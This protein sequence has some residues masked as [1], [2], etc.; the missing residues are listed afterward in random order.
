MISEKDVLFV[1]DGDNLFRTVRGLYGKEYRVSYVRL[2]DA[3][4]VGRPH[5]MCYHMAMFH[6]VMRDMTTQMGF[7]SRLSMLGYDV[8]TATSTIDPDTGEVHRK[9]TA[10]DIIAYIRDFRC[11]DRFPKTV[12]VAS[13][14]GAFA[15]LYTALTYQGVTVE[16][17]YFGDTLSQ[18]IQDVAR[19]T[20][21]DEA[22]LYTM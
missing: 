9:S 8:H 12:V 11:R 6:T 18:R 7:I 17:L 19:V 14:S 22:V 13:A 20:V 4:R 3:L 21:L 15:D 5:D 1:A 16:L 2:K 10:E